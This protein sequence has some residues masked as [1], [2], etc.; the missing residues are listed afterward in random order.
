[1]LCYM[2]QSARNQ[3]YHEAQIHLVNHSLFYLFPTLASE[4]VSPSG[5]SIIEKKNSDIIV[6]KK[7]D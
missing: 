5:S 1:M 6:L 4:V 2:V 3:T 7:I